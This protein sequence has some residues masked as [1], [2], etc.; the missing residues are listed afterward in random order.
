MSLKQT[1]EEAFARGVV[2]PGD[3]N[4]TRCPYNC[5][6]CQRVAA[7][8]KGKLW[9]GHTT[10]ELRAQHVALTLSTPEAFQYFLP[11]FMLVS[12]WIHTKKGM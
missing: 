1:I 4:I 12:L 10:E 9:T 6:E 3:N 7:F 8:F 2:Y 11:A 5:T